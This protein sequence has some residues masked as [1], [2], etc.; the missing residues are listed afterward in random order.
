M[1]ILPIAIALAL[2]AGCAPVVPPPAPAPAAAAPKTAPSAAAAADRLPPREAARA[3]ARVV[4]RVEP[5]AEALCRSEGVVEN[6]DY[7]VVVDDRRDAPPNA[8]QTVG[9]GGRP[10]VGLTLALIADARNEDEL[11]FIL[12]HE[13]AHHVAGH[14]D[15][16]RQGALEGQALGEA[17][18]RARGLDARGVRE[19]ARAGAFIGARRF[20][21]A[22]EL[23]A[24]ALGTVIADAAGYD[25][26]RGSAFFQ[27]IPDPG[28]QFLGTH[29]PNAERIET[30]R[31]VAAGL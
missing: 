30:V 20:G 13:M 19:F 29:P 31:R 10:V 22:F 11:A 3:F 16:A 2:L 6:C 14:L 5:V 12:S 7:R 25:P 24:D 15:L 26:V 27:R 1:R 4:E 28:D 8:F 17:I 18:G 9:R 23:E 21:P